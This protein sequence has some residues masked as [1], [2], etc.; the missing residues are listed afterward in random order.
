MEEA[1][2]RKRIDAVLTSF[3]RYVAQVDNPDN[4]G[5]NEQFTSFAEAGSKLLDLYRQNERLARINE[6][7][8]LN[9]VSYDNNWIDHDDYYREIKKRLAELSNTQT[10]DNVI[11]HGNG[12]GEIVIDDLSNTHKTGENDEQN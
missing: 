1:E 8:M 7:N 11:N 10:S 5:E 4:F 9:E 3:G 12:V 2:L 6:L